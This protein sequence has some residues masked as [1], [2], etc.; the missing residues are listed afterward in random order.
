MKEIIKCLVDNSDFEEYK[1][2]Y[3]QS[4]ICAYARIDG[5]S[6]GIVANQRKSIKTK[7]RRTSIRRCHIF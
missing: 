7:K 1:K 4:I 2:E 6:V 5:W 3:G